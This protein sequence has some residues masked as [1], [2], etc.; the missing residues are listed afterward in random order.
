MFI[1]AIWVNKTFRTN[2]KPIGMAKNPHVGKDGPLPEIQNVGM[3][4]NPLTL[5]ILFDI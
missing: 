4:L 3:V 5:I 1:F 2:P